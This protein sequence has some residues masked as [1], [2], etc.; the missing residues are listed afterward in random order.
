[1]RRLAAPPRSATR[2]L[3]A[4]VGLVLAALACG[5]LGWTVGRLVSPPLGLA[6]VSQIGAPGWW[7]LAWGAA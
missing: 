3:L 5:A 2:L 6:I 1:M 7:L 4:G